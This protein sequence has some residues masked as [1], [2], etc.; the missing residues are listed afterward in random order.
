[1]GFL[2]HCHAVQLS[3]FCEVHH[4]K[5]D[6]AIRHR[7]G[8][9]VITCLSVSLSLSVNRITQNDNDVHEILLN[10]WGQII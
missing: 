8:N 4:I 6:H 7:I 1:V 2:R 3:V 9:Y 5:S 10:G